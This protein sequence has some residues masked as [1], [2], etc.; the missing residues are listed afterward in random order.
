MCREN[1]EIGAL[2]FAKQFW[3]QGTNLSPISAK[4]LLAA[5]SLVGLCQ[6]ADKYSISRTATLFC[7]AGA[8]YRVRARLQSKHLSRRWLRVV[9]Q[10]PPGKSLLPLEWWIDRGKPGR[11]VRSQCKP[12]DLRLVP[13]DLAFEGERAMFEY[14]LYHN[15]LQLW[16]KWLYWYCSVALGP[17]PS[18]NDLFSPPIVATSWRRTSFDATI[19][20]KL[21]IL[22]L[23]LHQAF[24]LKLLVI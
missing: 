22:L 21:A 10:R 15:W 7:L 14:T 24:L 4:A 13:D 19:K 23:L 1:L 16:L 6:F 17:D 9:A 2:E 18:L 20:K 8:G 5:H 3:V 11:L 12:K